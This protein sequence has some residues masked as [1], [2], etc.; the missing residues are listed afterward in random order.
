[1]DE[2]N[3]KAASAF[4]N[5]TRS[6]ANAA[7]RARQVHHGGFEVVDPETDMIQRWDMHLFGSEKGAYKKCPWLNIDIF[8]IVGARNSQLYLGWS[9]W[10]QGLHKIDLNGV[11]A[12]ACE[13][14]VFVNIL[15]L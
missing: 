9:R 15:F 5:A 6:E 7:V 11:R 3:V 1:M 2:T 10:V 13:Q 12:V 4:A 8:K 14:D